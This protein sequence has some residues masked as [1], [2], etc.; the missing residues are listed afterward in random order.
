MFQLNNTNKTFIFISLYLTVLVGFFINENSTG[1]ALI[2]FKMRMNVIYNF[3]LDFFETFKNYNKFGD[4]HS[5]IILIVLSLLSR[6]GI[7][8]DVIRFIHLHLLILIFL[9]SYR[10]LVLKYPNINKNFFYLISLVF[11]LSPTMRSNAI[12]PDSRVLGL[13][14]F[15]CSVFFF[16]KFQKDKEFKNC[17]YNNIL[18]VCSAYISPN[19]SLFFI[20]FFYYYLKYYGVSKNIY[21]VI[22]INSLLSLP[23]LLYLFVFKINFLS[24]VAIPE[25]SIFTRLNIFNKVLIISTLIFFYL[26]PFTLNKH[27]INKFYNNFNKNIFFLSIIVF[28]LCLYFFNYSI[29]FTGGGIFFKLSYLIFDN[30]YLFHII[31]FISLVTIGVIFKFNLN[32]II[33]FL[34]LIL[35][36]PQLTIY[37]KYYDPL[38]IL[39]YFLLFEFNFDVRKVINNKFIYN[40]YC[41]YIIFLAIN[42][43][44]NFYK[45]NFY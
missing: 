20:Y 36:N 43:S 42:L 27:F 18:L 41:F 8:I 25:I 11:L 6:F 13:L 33:L 1:G 14:I 19:F 38:L 3:H 29:N 24:V 17:L 37:H 45:F 15:L 40:I 7:S 16:I 10:C 22:F 2:D 39:L 44:R 9:L 35:S 12:W 26:I 21:K 28:F 4:R 5:P 32:N 30:D 23:M 31:S 34:I